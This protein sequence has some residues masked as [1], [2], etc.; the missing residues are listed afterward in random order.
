[1]ATNPL[2]NLGTLNRIQASVVFPSNPTLNVTG[3]YLSKRGVRMELL[4]DLTQM[5]DTMT[6]LLPSPEPYVGADVTISLV[7]TLS[8][9]ATWITQ[10]VA[11]TP[12]GNLTV[13]PDTS[14]Y[15]PFNFINGAVMRAPA[16]SS[17]GDESFVDCVIRAT[18]PIN[19]NLWILA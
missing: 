18:F 12:V 3:A 7:K 6:G 9:A 16:N 17:A 8:L 13:Y 10:I 2:L 15:P 4:G 11:G 19:Q 5:L 14:S 1:M